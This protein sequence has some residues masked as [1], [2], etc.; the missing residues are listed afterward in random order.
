MCG[1]QC[2]RC[3]IVN[4]LVA[5]SNAQRGTI[6]DW[7]FGFNGNRGPKCPWL[8]YASKVSWFHISRCSSRPHSCYSQK[9]E[10]VQ[11]LPWTAI[12]LHT[13]GI[14]KKQQ[15]KKQ[16]QH[17]R[18]PVLCD[19]FLSP[20]FQIQWLLLFYHT[21]KWKFTTAMKIDFYG[22]G[23][24][25]A[26][27]VHSQ[28]WWGGTSIPA[29]FT[30]EKPLT[31]SFTYP[32]TIQICLKAISISL[33]RL[34]TKLQEYSTADHE[35]SESH[36]VFIAFYPNYLARAVRNLRRCPF[37]EHNSNP[38]V[39]II[40][41]QVKRQASSAFC[42]S[43]I[44]SAN[45]SANSTPLNSSTNTDQL[46]DAQRIVVKA[47]V[48]IYA[49]CNLPGA[50][51]TCSTAHDIVTTSSCSTT[52]TA[53]FKRFP[54]RD[55]EQNITFLTQSSYSVVTISSGVILTQGLNNRD[56][57]ACPPPTQSTYVQKIVTYHVCHWRALTSNDPSSITLIICKT[58]FAGRV[59]CKNI[60]EVWM[61]YTEYFPTITTNVIHIDQFFQCVSDPK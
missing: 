58:D 46:S 5:S 59:S 57:V 11:D 21:I 37:L 55:C 20:P 50:S 44:W 13:L 42:N 17:A 15:Q 6:Y 53:A 47:T 2:Y 1:D 19:L 34:W 35:L 4:Y 26:A 40:V 22:S 33:F 41:P 3:V 32:Y 16:Q 27:T 29:L 38:P 43:S 14:Q 45:Y 52:I 60:Q 61:V 31:T 24:W 8:W 25:N 36:H 48:P 23:V 51:S 54:I 9:C 18:S 7:V 49:V 39:P 10:F 30:I 56:D 12:E 28:G